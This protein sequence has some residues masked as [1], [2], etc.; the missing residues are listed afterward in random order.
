MVSTSEIILAASE[1]LLTGALV[2][3]DLL[4]EIRVGPSMTLPR[5]SS[6]ELMT[7]PPRALG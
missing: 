5:I 3:L 2:L 6:F 4:P 1:A 7:I